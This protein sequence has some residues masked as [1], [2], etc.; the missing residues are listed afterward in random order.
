MAKG[1]VVIRYKEG[2]EEKEKS[3]A[4]KNPGYNDGGL[5]F[6]RVWVDGRTLLIA[7]D[8]VMTIDVTITED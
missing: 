4:G 7:R 5:S 8:A 1:K 2:L 6:V 3:L